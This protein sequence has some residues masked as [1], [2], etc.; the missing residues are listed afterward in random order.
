M[1]HFEKGAAS[2]TPRLF[3][4]DFREHSLASLWRVDYGDIRVHF[5]LHVCGRRVP[6]AFLH[7][8]R[9]RGQGRTFV[10][11]SF[12]F[13][14]AWDRFFQVSYL[15]VF[16]VVPLPRDL[17]AHTFGHVADALAPDGFVEFHVDAHV[18]GLFRDRTCTWG[19]FPRFSFPSLATHVSSSLGR[20][21]WVTIGLFSFVR[22]FVVVWVVSL[23]RF[24]VSIRFSSSFRLSR[25]CMAFFAKAL[26][27]LTAL[28]ARFLKA[29]PCNLLCRFLR[30][31]R[32]GLPGS[33]FSLHLSLSLSLLG[34]VT[35]IVYS[36]VTASVFPLAMATCE[37]PVCVCAS[38]LAIPPDGGAP[39]PS[40]L[41][42][43]IA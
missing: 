34:C 22:S 38:W 21:A 42:N 32:R 2:I 15:C 19:Q 40:P 10:F 35:H 5:L 20:R 12:R 8:D 31:R 30:R 23:D 17:H 7:H 26:I 14:D 43:P 41:L 25:T 27:S 13:A 29:I 16:V 1:V 11:V 3:V 28:G 36:R 37:T 9:G 24:L 4:E 18:F 33:V 39:P 6:S